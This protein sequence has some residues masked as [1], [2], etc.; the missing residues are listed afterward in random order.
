MDA[1]NS[2]GT[3]GGPKSKPP[4]GRPFVQGDPRINRS[5]RPPGMAR[6]IRELAGDD[7]DKLV[8]IAWK[9]A[10]GKLLVDKPTA[11]GIVALPPTAKERLEAVEWLGRQGFGEP[12]K[13]VELTGANGGPVDIQAWDLTGLSDDEL[14]L[15]EQLQ[16]RM[17]SNRG[18]DSAGEG[19]PDEGETPE[20]VRGVARGLHP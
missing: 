11:T 7:G 3:G 6:R 4:V 13:R 17:A 8:N 5:G 2:D 14:Q 9:I 15:V 19:T 20:Q 12:P 16:S 10:R 18:G 1:G